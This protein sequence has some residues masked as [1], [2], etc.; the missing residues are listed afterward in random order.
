MVV[1][2][3]HR[4]PRSRE[5]SLAF[6]RLTNTFARTAFLHPSSIRAVSAQSSRRMHHRDKPDN[7][8]CRGASSR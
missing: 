6:L 1:R 2:T 7:H 5:H 4:L 8:A 3:E